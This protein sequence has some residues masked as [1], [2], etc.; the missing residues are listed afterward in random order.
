MAK[1]TAT[2]TS[3][4]PTATA[5]TPATPSRASRAAKAAATA[6]PAPRAPRRSIT[7]DVDNDL[8]PLTRADEARIQREQQTLER[9]EAMTPDSKLDRDLAH[10]ADPQAGRRV[11]SRRRREPDEESLVYRGK[12]G[13]AL[14]VDQHIDVIVPDDE[15]DERVQDLQAVVPGM[16]EDS[17][18]EAWNT[19]AMV[20]N[21][22]PA[23]YVPLADRLVVSG[24]HYHFELGKSTLVHRDD[25]DYLL[26]YPAYIIERVGDINAEDAIPAA[27]VRRNAAAVSNQRRRA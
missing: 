9:G 2:T 25:V 19:A 22:E 3:T 21:R 10:L 14:L 15:N 1:R 16:D 5:A 6:V 26:A 27:I 11:P 20:R 12:R 4:R 8:M 13:R 23:P 24:I 18:R 7:V 17:Q